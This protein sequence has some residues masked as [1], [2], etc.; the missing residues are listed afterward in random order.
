MAEMLKCISQPRKQ[1]SQYAPKIEQ[2]SIPAEKIGELIGP[3]GK[4]IKEIIAKSGAQVDVEEDKDK[5]IGLVFISSPD[6]AA[7]D[8]ASTMVNNLTRVVEVGDEFDGRVVRIEGY[9][10]FVEYLPGRD[11]LVHVS[12]MSADYVDDPNSLVKL[13][14]TV[15]VWINEIKEDGKIGLAMLS[16]DEM[17]EAKNSPEARGA[18]PRP[19][20]RGGRDD[21][22]D[23]GGDRGG[24]GYRGDYN[25]DQHHRS[26]DRNKN[27]RGQVHQGGFKSQ[28]T[29]E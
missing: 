7:I 19:A 10:A 22:N 21:R 29:K 24:R 20:F 18:R 13:G 12:A 9:G 16:P 14:D 2:I 27:S 26:F 15:H 11:G 4:M 3:G 25:S 8:A 23:R 17:K 5:G 28:L 6:Q 1:L